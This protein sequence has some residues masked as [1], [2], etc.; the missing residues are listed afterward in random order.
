[1]SIRCHD[2]ETQQEAAHKQGAV[3]SHQHWFMNEVA[4]GHHGSLQSEFAFPT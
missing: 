4:S 3:L 1:L 2:K